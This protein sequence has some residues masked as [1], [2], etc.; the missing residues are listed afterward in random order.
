MSKVDNALAQRR[1]DAVR[2]VQAM[3][4][5]LIE[6]RRKHWE[7]RG[8]IQYNYTIVELQD[9]EGLFEEAL[10]TAQRL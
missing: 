5:D 6:A 2:A 8:V 4:P 10:A 9:L 3:V 7:A 1:R